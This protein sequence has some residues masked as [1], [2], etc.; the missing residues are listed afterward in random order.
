MK[1]N[2]PLL[3][4]LAVAILLAACTAHPQAVQECVSGQPVGF[5]MGLWHGIIAP[6]TFI[7]SL[8]S[9]N[10]TVYEMNNNG[11]WYNFGFLLGV[12]AFTS[13]GLLGG[14]RARRRR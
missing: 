2:L 13:G 14:N 3:L 9:E 10:I 8:F 11:G 12:G 1:K 5:W 6:F 4:I 7:I